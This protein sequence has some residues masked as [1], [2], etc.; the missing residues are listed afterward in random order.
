MPDPM[1]GN[2]LIVEAMT[3][4]EKSADPTTLSTFVGLFV[5]MPTLPAS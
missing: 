2:A 3:D 1:P 5:P 4:V